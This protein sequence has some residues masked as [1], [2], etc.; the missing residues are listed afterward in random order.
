VLILNE[1]FAR[2]W[3][4]CA[5]DSCSRKE[6]IDVLVGLTH[7]LYR[8]YAQHVPVFWQDSKMGGRE[9][10]TRFRLTGMPIPDLDEQ[11]VMGW[12]DVKMTRTSGIVAAVLKGGAR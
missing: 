6:P 5:V 10:E 4:R 7:H 2:H 11:D 8:V 1:E 12:R 3:Q 9:D